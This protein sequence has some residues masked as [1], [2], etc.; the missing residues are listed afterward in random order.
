MAGS[1]PAESVTCCHD[2]ALRKDIQC[3]AVNINIDDEST[4]FQAPPDTTSSASQL[5]IIRTI[6]QLA[7]AAICLV[8]SV[9]FNLTILAV[10]HERVPRSMPPLPDVTFAIL[11]KN[12]SALDI[13]E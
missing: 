9:L 2:G 10:I 13:S 1:D 3:H 4:P 7:V 6:P 11:P 12:S 5:S 8:L